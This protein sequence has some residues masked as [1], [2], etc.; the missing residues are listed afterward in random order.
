MKNIFYHLFNIFPEELKTLLNC[1]R[2]RKLWLEQKVIFIHV[3][4]TGGT[5][6]SH[7][8]Y[9]RSLGHLKSCDIKRWCPKE[10][11]DLFKFGFT[12][13][14]W[15]RAVSAYRFARKG[16]T[17]TAGIKNFKQYQT[18]DFQDF[19]TFVN[20]WLSSK[21]LSKVDYVFQPQYP[22]ILDDEDQILLDF[23][24]KLETID[25]DIEKISTHTKRELQVPVLNR[26]TAPGS[27]KSYYN[28]RHLINKVGDIYNKDTE[29]FNY[30]Y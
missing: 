4:K 20:E 19:E 1:R 6:V 16:S 23:V 13:N 12:R 2:R 11:E 21:D 15:D 24:G 30:D 22:F 10:F 17:E 3:P 28:N 25:K 8:L 29:R 5:S 7:A 26:V 14:P 27:Y 9:G 18:P